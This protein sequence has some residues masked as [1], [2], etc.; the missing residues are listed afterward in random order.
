MNRKIYLDG[1]RFISCRI[2]NCEHIDVYSF[3][4]PERKEELRQA[5]I[6]NGYDLVKPMD[7]EPDDI[8]VNRKYFHFKGEKYYLNQCSDIFDWF[9]ESQVYEFTYYYDRIVFHTPTGYIAAYIED[10]SNYM[11]I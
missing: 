1:E 6:E 8:V 7:E 3:D 2:S 4:F 11:R 10:T 5:M 9:G